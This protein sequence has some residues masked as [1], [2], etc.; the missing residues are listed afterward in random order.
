[1][2]KATQKKTASAW[3]LFLNVLLYIAENQKNEPQRGVKTLY[4]KREERVCRLFM[5]F[6]V[7]TLYGNVVINRRPL[8]AFANICKLHMIK[9]FSDLRLMFPELLHLQPLWE[10]PNKLSYKTFP[11]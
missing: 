7:H 6:I 2:S 1:M 10:T 11:I 9:Y 8:Y 3:F 4:F 5:F